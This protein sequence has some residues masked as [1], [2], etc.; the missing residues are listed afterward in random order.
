MRS[1]IGTELSAD[2]LATARG[3][4][5]DVGAVADVERTIDTLLD[6]AVT[7]L[8]STDIDDAV[9]TDLVAVARRMAHR[10]A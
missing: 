2:E 9:Y 1:V 10:D 3:I 5:T 6:S 4:L 8:E 7:T